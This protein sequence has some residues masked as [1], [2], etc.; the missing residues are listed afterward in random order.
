MLNKSHCHNG[1]KKY[2]LEFGGAM[3]AYIGVLCAVVFTRPGDT[4]HQGK[5]A[6]IELLPA[7]PLLLAFWAIIR[8]FRRMDEF[9]QR[10]HAEAFALGA[11]TWG[12][13]IMIWGF[14]EN[15]GAPV[16]SSMFMAPGLIALWGLCTPIVLRRYK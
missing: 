4:G 15:A 1:I 8:H 9:Y 12:L 11:L 5:T 13:F 7:I 2:A 10:V 3:M 14:A 16:L 6:V